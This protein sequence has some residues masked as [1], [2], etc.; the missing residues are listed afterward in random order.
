MLKS[1]VMSAV[2]QARKA[3]Q[4]LGVDGLIIQRIQKPYV[5][6][7]VPDYT[8]IRTAVKVVMSGYKS[9][10]IDGDRIQARDLQGLVFPIDGTDIVPEPNDV[11]RIDDIDYRVVS[12][13]KVM[14]G[15]TVALS[16]LQLRIR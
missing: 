5:P 11:I 14:A 15:N 12:N 10:E 16:Q 7:T 9:F 6:G 2:S 1:V 8:E 13:E 3:V 4:D